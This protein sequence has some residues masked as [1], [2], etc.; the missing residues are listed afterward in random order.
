MKFEQDGGRGDG[1]GLP[2]SRLR[3]C[4][5]LALRN[6]DGIVDENPESILGPRSESF[7][8]GVHVFLAAVSDHIS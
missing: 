7:C 8:Y 5:A 6:I 1:G 2:S 3:D 4:R